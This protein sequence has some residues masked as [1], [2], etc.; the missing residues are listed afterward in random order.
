MQSLLIE[1]YILPAQKMGRCHFSGGLHRN[2]KDCISGA[3]NCTDLME[4][5]S[6]VSLWVQSDVKSKF[7][8]ASSFWGRESAY[9]L[10]GALRRKS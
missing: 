5:P 7:S 4:D 8:R 3:A 6:R 1:N 10:S 9:A 2:V